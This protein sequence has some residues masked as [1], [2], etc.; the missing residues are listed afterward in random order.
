NRNLAIPMFI[1]FLNNYLLALFAV[2]AS[3]VLPLFAAAYLPVTVVLLIVTRG[4]MRETG[5]RQGSA[6]AGTQGGLPGRTAASPQRSQCGG[7][8][9][10]LLGVRIAARNTDRRC[11]DLRC[12]AVCARH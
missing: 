4:S 6:S 12:Q 7:D 9:V 8:A 11:I 1:H 10:G 3:Q 5:L 2:E